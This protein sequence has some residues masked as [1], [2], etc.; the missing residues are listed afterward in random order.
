MEKFI[1]KKE[2]EVV[3]TARELIN[4]DISKMSELE[5][6][7]MIIRIVAGLEDSTK[8]TVESLPIEIKELKSNQ[9]NIKN[10]RAEMQ[11]KVK[12]IKT[13]K[14]MDCRGRLREHS[15]LL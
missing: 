1:P 14:V 7:A 13:R 10:T 5:F 2:H 8:D 9:A 4:T 6:K 15:H 3:L 12:A 11:S